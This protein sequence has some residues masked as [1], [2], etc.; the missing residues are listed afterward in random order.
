[1]PVTLSPSRLAWALVTLAAWAFA[2]HIVVDTLRTVVPL[3]SPLP[4]FDEWATVELIRAWQSGESSLPQI[5]FAQHNEHRILVPRLVFFTDDLLFGGQGHASL[6]AIMLVQALHAG[7]FATLL[8]RAR[9]AG[10]WALAAVVVALMFSLRQAENFTYG[11][12]VQF[13]GVFA[14]AGASFALFGLAVAR[15]RRGRPIAPALVAAALAA[16]VT[17]LTMANG[18]AAGF[19]LVALSLLARMPRRVTLA[20]AAWAVL[21]AAVYL[22]GYV[23]VAHHTR[24]VES[25]DHPLGLLLYVATYLGGMGAP[26]P[27]AV[28]AALGVLGLLATA[29]AVARAVRV[30]AGAVE[31]TLVGIMLF[32]GAAAAVTGAGRLGFGIDQ[33]LSSRYA[34]GSAA[35]WAAQLA[36]WW[37]V[38]PRLP[39]PRPGLA[40]AGVAAVSLLLVAAMAQAQG[41]AKPEIARQSFALHESADLLLT[42]LHDPEVLGRTAWVVPDVERLLP[43]LRDD[44][45]SIFA[46]REAA[47]LGRPVSSL[48]RVAAGGCGGGVAALADPGLGPDGVRVSG[49]AEPG[50]GRALPR[51]IVVADATGTV[52]GLGSGAVPGAP[53]GSWRGFA[54]AA[55]GARLDA[56][57]WLPDRSLCRVGNATVG[58]REPGSAAPMP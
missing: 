24:P 46:T 26:G 12:Q 23:P 21:L 6:A 22:N 30:G 10:R 34:T 39:P 48:G 29:A 5:L 37:T 41:G 54:T 42:G 17:A 27:A 1:M 43:V 25:L 16:L 51:R 49:V 45:L 31:L 56:F 35:F 32:V 47:A 7:L 14:G 20:C 38:A 11:F 53:R 52:V 58:P 28:P 55:A 15:R 18:L 8:A 44:S 19:V 2:G 40:R 9:G 33:A 13:V 3:W 57:G 50:P 4:W 36:Y